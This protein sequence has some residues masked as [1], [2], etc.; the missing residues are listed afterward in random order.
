MEMREM[1]F[2]LLYKNKGFGD[3]ERQRSAQ[4]QTPEN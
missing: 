2:P 3:K 4:T 1:T